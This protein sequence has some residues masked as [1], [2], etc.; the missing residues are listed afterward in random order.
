MVGGGTLRFLR[1]GGGGLDRDRENI[2]ALI[3]CF[4]ILFLWGGDITP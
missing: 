1:V 2:G 4:F 3:E